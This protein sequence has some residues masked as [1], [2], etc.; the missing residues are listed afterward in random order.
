[1]SSTALTK[2][3]LTSIFNTA[4][5]A[6]E[7]LGETYKLTDPFAS[8]VSKTN[9]AIAKSP[10]LKGM[11]FDQV[12][13]SA[14]LVDDNDKLTSLANAAQA[15]L[16]F[17]KGGWGVSGYSIGFLQLDLGQR[18]KSTAVSQGITDAIGNETLAAYLAR[19]IKSDVAI[20]MSADDLAKALTW[21]LGNFTDSCIP[22]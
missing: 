6:T 4:I 2:G 9:G 12:A 5:G 1:M 3:Q 21:N 14:T 22:T 18:G 19:H 13:D 11:T 7:G 10:V 17:G 8:V 16:T 15:A 20:G